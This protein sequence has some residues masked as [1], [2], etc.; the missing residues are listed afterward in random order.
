MKNDSMCGR[1]ALTSTSDFKKRFGILGEI[2]KFE[3]SY[4]ISPATYNP[5]IIRNS[6]ND[7][8][9]MKWGLIPFWA[10]KYKLETGFINARSEGILDKASFKRPIK[11]Q[12]CL[13]PATG[14]YEWKK[15]KLEI[16]DEKIPYYFGIKN[17]EIFSFAGIYDVWND[18]EGKEIF[19]YAIITTSAN[20]IMRNVHDRMPVILKPDDEEK[21]LYK[22]TD[23]SEILK[24]LLPYNHREMFSYPVS[25]LVNNPKND[26]GDLIRRISAPE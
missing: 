6:P 2:S 15:V 10:K 19:T 26:S 23:I 3:K 12:R 9:M 5:V 21:Y 18:S 13:V 7:L 16:K 11:Y 1:Y 17:R 8:V 24:I 20:E 4:N 22:D 25:K 14:F